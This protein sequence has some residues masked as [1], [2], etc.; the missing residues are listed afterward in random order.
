MAWPGQ[1]WR[2]KARIFFRGKIRMSHIGPSE[3]REQRPLRNVLQHTED[4]TGVGW[5]ELTCGHREQAGSATNPEPK[6]RKQ[7]RCSS[8]PIHLPRSPR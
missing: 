8:C 1:A 4:D 3:F 6:Q 7:R 2:G 5:D